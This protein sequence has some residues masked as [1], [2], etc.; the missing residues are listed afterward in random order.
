M[1]YNGHNILAIIVAAIAIYAIEFVIFAL[2]IPGATYAQMVGI[3]M[4]QA[5]NMG[6]MPYGAIMPV[7]QAIGLSCAVKWRG[8]IGPVAGAVTGIILAVFFATAVSMYQYVYAAAEP[9]W[10]VVSLGHFVLCY[11]VAGIVLGAWK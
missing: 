2:F 7:L 3:S 4:D 5:G 6:R 10:I 8:A 9:I 1:R 11:A